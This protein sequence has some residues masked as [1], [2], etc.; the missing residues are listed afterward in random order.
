MEVA[1]IALDTERNCHNIG[2]YENDWLDPTSTIELE[3]CSRRPALSPSVSVTGKAK[4]IL[5]CF[6]N[7]V[8][9]FD[10]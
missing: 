2:L 10:H 8:R 3:S 1:A 9:R 7:L 4:A 6:E 5:F